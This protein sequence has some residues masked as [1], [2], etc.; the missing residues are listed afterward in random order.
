MLENLGLQAQAKRERRRSETDLLPS[1][2]ADMQTKRER[3]GSDTDFDGMGF[4]RK[5]KLSFTDECAH[6]RLIQNAR[7]S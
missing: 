1:F 3:R 7:A 2:S 5:R 6:A 4:V